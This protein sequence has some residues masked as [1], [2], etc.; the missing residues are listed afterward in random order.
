MEQKAEMSGSSLLGGDPALPAPPEKPSRVCFGRCDRRR[1]TISAG[2][3]SH[4][5]WMDILMINMDWESG[6]VTS[7]PLQCVCWLWPWLCSASCSTSASTVRPSPRPATATQT[8]RS[9]GASASGCTLR[10]ASSRTATVSRASA[11]RRGVPGGRAGAGRGS[12]GAFVT[13]GN[14]ST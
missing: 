7:W 1:M 3:S 9:V 4:R 12:P 10:R 8:S 14:C 2:R 11:D 6:A 13:G 5:S